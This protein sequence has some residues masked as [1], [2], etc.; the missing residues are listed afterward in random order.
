MGEIP[1][2]QEVLRNLKIAYRKLKHYIYYDTSNALLRKQLADFESDL[3]FE[4]KLLKLRRSLSRYY[5]TKTADAHLKSLIE[6]N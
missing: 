2:S 5:R 1:N 3:G 4:R 6:K